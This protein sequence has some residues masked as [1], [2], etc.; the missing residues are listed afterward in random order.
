MNHD[1][2]FNT[3][4]MSMGKFINDFTVQCVEKFPQIILHLL[5]FQIWTPCCNVMCP[6]KIFPLRYFLSSNLLV[7]IVPVHF[8]CMHL[9]LHFWNFQNVGTQKKNSKRRHPKKFFFFQFGH[10]ILQFSKF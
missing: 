5:N 8:I 7:L 2:T 1:V 6:H 9:H 3:Y 10:P 4:M